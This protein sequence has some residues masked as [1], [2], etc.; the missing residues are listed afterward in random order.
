MQDDINCPFFG[1]LY[2]HAKGLAVGECGGELDA[3]KGAK[4]F[5]RGVPAI[6]CVAEYAD[7]MQTWVGHLSLSLILSFVQ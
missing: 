5:D 4:P 6:G 1:D 3:L 2:A 7:L